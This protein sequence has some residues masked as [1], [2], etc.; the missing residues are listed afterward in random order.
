MSRLHFIALVKLSLYQHPHDFFFLHGSVGRQL[1][2]DVRFGHE[3]HQ[4]LH[5]LQNV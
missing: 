5:V 3:L 1:L 4:V 2:A